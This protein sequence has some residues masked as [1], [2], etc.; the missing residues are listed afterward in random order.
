MSL[1]MTA[2]D[3]KSAVDRHNEVRR[4][5]T[6]ASDMELITYSCDIEEMA[7]KQADKCLITAAISQIR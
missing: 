4:Q 5:Q 3:R 6:G 1:S 2:E 7:Q